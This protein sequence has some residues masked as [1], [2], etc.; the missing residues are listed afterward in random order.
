MSVEAE[1]DLRDVESRVAAL[2]NKVS[3]LKKGSY[4][5]FDLVSKLEDLKEKQ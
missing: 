4:E 2:E 5:Y 1:R 3:A